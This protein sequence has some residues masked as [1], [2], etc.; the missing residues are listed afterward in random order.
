MVKLISKA[1]L[2]RAIN[3]W[4]YAD[5][6]VFH[7]VACETIHQIMI[8]LRESQ[9]EPNGHTNFLE[10]IESA[11]LLDEKLKKDIEREFYNFVLEAIRDIP[12][13]LE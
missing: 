2:D 10:Y 9:Q 6:L 5:I 7:R 13:P 11:K 4:G 12:F 1:K 8:V 3:S